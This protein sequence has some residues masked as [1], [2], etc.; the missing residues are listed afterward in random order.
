[1]CYHRMPHYFL[2]PSL[3]GGGEVFGKQGVGCSP[4]PKHYLYILCYRANRGAIF[5]IKN[6]Y[7]KLQ[8]YYIIRTLAN[9][10]FV[11]LYTHLP[12]IHANIIYALVIDIFHTTRRIS[13]SL[14]E[15]AIFNHLFSTTIVFNY[16]VDTGIYFYWKLSLGNN[17]GF[18]IF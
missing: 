16:K 14:L 9:I 3:M 6:S 15:T 2:K 17:I 13:H 1:M 4:F 8:L 5:S 18:V 10:P 12:H 11:H 7:C